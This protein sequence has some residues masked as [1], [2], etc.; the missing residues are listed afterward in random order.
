MK[1]RLLEKQSGADEQQK[2]AIRKKNRK[3]QLFGAGGEI[4]GSLT[5]AGGRGTG[6]DA[7]AT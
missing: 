6:K 1:A 4:S 5:L 2:N 3:G 7:C